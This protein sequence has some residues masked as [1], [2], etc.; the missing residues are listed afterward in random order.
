MRFGLIIDFIIIED[1][2]SEGVIMREKRKIIDI[3]NKV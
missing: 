1:I 2:G 3:W